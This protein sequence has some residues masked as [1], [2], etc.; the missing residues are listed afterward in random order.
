METEMD[1]PKDDGALGPVRKGLVGVQFLFVAFGGTVLM[2]LLVGLDPA[3]ALFSAG[4][5]TLL[6]HA[7]T[8]GQVPVFLG[9]SFTYIAPILAASALWGLDGALAGCVGVGA[10]YLAAAGCVR[11]RGTG[12]LDRL[13]PPVVVGPVIVLIGLTLAPSAVKMAS[14]DWGIALASLAAAVAVVS[15]GRGM[16]RL[17]PMLAGVA[18]G[19]AL[20]AAL[21]KVDFSGIAAAP[22]FALPANLAHPR[23]PRFA[24]QPLAF[25]MPVAVATVIEH[26]GDIYVVGQV[27]GRDFVHKPGLHRTL[28]GDAL[29]ILFGALAGGPPVTTYSEVTGAVQITRVTEPSVLRI[30]ALAAIAFSVLGKVGAFLQSIPQAVLGGIMLMLFG[31]IAGVGIQGMVRHKVDFS[32]SRNLVI[33]GLVLTLGVGGAVFKAGSFSL[34]GIGLAAVVGMGL[35]LALPRGDG[36]QSGT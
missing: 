1:K 35:N 32:D 26:V 3:T 10:V 22:W 24:W 27:A 13:F 9:S 28:L 4:V 11:W 14:E 8:G 34:G 16:F 36:G 17:L 30:T 23:L 20:A 7:V 21:G 12:F 18:A 6:F 31:T 33:A 25:L 2:P 19:Y 29:A 15:W 5:G